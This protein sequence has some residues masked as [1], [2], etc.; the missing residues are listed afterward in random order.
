MRKYELVIVID[1]RTSEE[2]RSKTIAEVEAAVG[3]DS[4]IQKDEIGAIEAAYDLSWKRWNNKIYLVSYYCDLSPERIKEIKA[5]IAYVKG[6]MRHFFYSM[7]PTQKFF[8]YK[9]L[10]DTF[11]KIEE[12]KEEA[13]EMKE[14]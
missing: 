2:D 1:G 7:K 13:S 10:Q 11:A 5:A 3:K 9:E 12:E 6:L 8:T 14:K 4:I